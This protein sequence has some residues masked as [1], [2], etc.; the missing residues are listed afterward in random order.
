MW[1]PVWHE[2]EDTGLGY[3]ENVFVAIPAVAF[4]VFCFQMAIPGSSPD[5]ASSSAGINQDMR[6]CLSVADSALHLQCLKSAIFWRT[7]CLSKV[8]SHSKVENVLSW[9]LLLQISDCNKTTLGD[10]THP[11]LANQSWTP[12]RTGYLIDCEVTP[13]SEALLK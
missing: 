5:F 7:L 2:F 9:P 8:F 10:S 12:C 11:L 4:F 3:L 6:P 13:P 1:F